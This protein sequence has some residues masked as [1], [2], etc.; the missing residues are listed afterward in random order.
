MEERLAD[1]L[2]KILE[3]ADAARIRLCPAHSLSDTLLS[4]AG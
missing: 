1:T 2:P 3:Q 4:G